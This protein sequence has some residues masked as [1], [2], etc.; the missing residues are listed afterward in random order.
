MSD[1][2]QQTAA[3]RTDAHEQLVKGP[4][5]WSPFDVG[6][7]HGEFARALERELADLRTKADTCWGAANYR[8]KYLGMM[9][10]QL[11]LSEEKMDSR[12]SEACAVIS[13]LRAERDALV[14]ERDELK[15]RLHRIIV[16]PHFTGQQ[17]GKGATP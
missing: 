16:N 2:P 6:A 3:P 13:A 5:A 11:G 4:N 10:R 9:F 12:I 15:M 14:K 8:L 7:V 1:A 17:L